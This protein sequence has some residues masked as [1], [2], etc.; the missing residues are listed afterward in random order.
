M[1]LAGRIDRLARE[2]EKSERIEWDVLIEYDP[3]YL[4]VMPCGFN[5]QETARRSVNLEQVPELADL[6]AIRNNRTIAVDA[7]AYF[8]R[9]GPR[10]IEGARLLGHLLHPERIEWKGSTDAF[11]VLDLF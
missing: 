3:D 1:R 7:E 4:F 11:R 5:A 6:T 10:I 8:S 9:P 2:G